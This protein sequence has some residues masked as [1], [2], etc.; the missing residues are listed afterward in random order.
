MANF[1]LLRQLSSPTQQ[2]QFVDPNQSILAQ[3]Q[4]RAQREGQLLRFFGKELGA[5]AVGRAGGGGAS[6]GP[7]ETSDLVRKGT[8]LIPRAEAAQ[9][10]IARKMAVA[11][12]RGNIKDYQKQLSLID[13]KQGSR[14]GKHATAI[15]RDLFANV[16]PTGNIV[17]GREQPVRFV[18]KGRAASETGPTGQAITNSSR[19]AGGAK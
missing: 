2:T 17:P 14:F 12:R 1:G 6:S 18:P 16:T 9:L 10:E 13:K 11:A 5:K 4:I 15:A 8:R 7:S 19:D 3:Q